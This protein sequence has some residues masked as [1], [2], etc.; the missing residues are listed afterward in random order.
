MPS[1]KISNSTCIMVGL[2]EGSVLDTTLAQCVN[3]FERVIYVDSQSTDHSLQI[4]ER[5]GVELLSVER[6]SA[7]Y[8]RQRALDYFEFADDELICFLDA[9]VLVSSAFVREASSQLEHCPHSVVFGYKLDVSHVGF[10]LKTAMRQINQPTFLGGNFLT[11]CSVISQF[12]TFFADLGVEEERH[13][14]SRLY[15]SGVGVVQI[16]AFQG[17]HLNY[18]AIDEVRGRSHRRVRYFWHLYFSSLKNPLVHQRIFWHIDFFILSV[19]FGIIISPVFLFGALLPMIS[20]T[21]L[22]QLGVFGNFD[23]RRY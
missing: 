21:N 23:L 20:L 22:H 15:E 9:D 12:E 18:K 17:Y 3:L 1:E 11:T 2:N 10:P 19:T 8:A 4:A 7:G 13:L 16:D 14:L 6:K 5:H